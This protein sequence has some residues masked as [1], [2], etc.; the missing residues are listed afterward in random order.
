MA[1][2]VH[3]TFAPSSVKLF[4]TDPGAQRCGPTGLGGGLG[5]GTRRTVV[6]GTGVVGSTKVKV[7]VVATVEGTV[8]VD[9]VAEVGRGDAVE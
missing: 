3:T 5:R 7:V 8:V 4:P 9:V 6:L 1:V 2:W